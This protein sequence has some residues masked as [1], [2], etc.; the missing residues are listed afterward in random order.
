MSRAQTATGSGKGAAVSRERAAHDSLYVCEDD[1]A[2]IE[3][4]VAPAQTQRL[5]RGFRLVAEQIRGESAASESRGST[6]DQG[7]FY[8][9]SFALRSAR[10]P[11][12]SKLNIG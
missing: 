1:W 2:C 3:Y 11:A 6:N 5:L 8:R 9:K 12:F 7:I 4:A 10:F